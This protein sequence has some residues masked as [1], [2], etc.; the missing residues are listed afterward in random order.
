[1]ADRARRSGASDP[2]SPATIAAIAAAGIWTFAV[3]HGDLRRDVLERN[4]AYFAAVAL[5]D[6]WD[7]QN[8]P[9]ESVGQNPS[10]PRDLF[11]GPPA[12][13]V[14]LP[15]VTIANVARFSAHFSY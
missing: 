1:M 5:V 8:P 12:L 11:R 3:P 15:S 7:G 10:R 13:R 4:T 9:S 6:R 2:P 14:P